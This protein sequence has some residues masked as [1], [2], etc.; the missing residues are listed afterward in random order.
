MR[1]KQMLL[2]ATVIGCLAV[3]SGAYAQEANTNGH[4]NARTGEQPNVRANGSM[5]QG[6][7]GNMNAQL[8]TRATSNRTSTNAQVEHF[9][10]KSPMNGSTREGRGFAERHAVRGDR[11]AH[12]SVSNERYG[13][14]WRGDRRLYAHA[15]IE[16]GYAYRDRA[17][18]AVAA[19]D[20]SYRT[21]HLYAYAPSYNVGYTARPYDNYAPGYD[22]A[23]NNG[24]YYTLGWEVAYGGPYY[25]YAPGVSFGIGI[26]PVGIGV[27]PAW[28]W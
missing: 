12:A 18:P 10:N 2:G 16:D 14:G 5:R 1:S 23:V 15:S 25:A 13:R 7:N 9:V 6:Q 11:G 8:N 17:I 28:G 3:T 4:F 24:P 21:R 22:V 20:Y 19:A 26:G 27:G